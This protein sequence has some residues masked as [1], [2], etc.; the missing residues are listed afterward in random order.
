MYQHAILKGR[1]MHGML[2][3]SFISEDNVPVLKD[4]H[5]LWDYLVLFKCIENLDRTFFSHALFL[6]SEVKSLL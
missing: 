1:S 2:L 4:S 3:F 6:S 5:L